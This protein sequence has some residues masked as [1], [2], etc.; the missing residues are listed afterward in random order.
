MMKKTIR[1]HVAMKTL[2]NFNICGLLVFGASVCKGNEAPQAA[3]G[4]AN[5]A[6]DKKDP[7]W[8]SIFPDGLMDLNGDDVPL[9]RLKGKMV[10]LYFSASWCAPCHLFTPHLAEFQ[11]QNEEHFEVVLVGRDSVEASQLGYMKKHNMAFP[12]TQWSDGKNTQ[13]DN[14]AEKHKVNSIP[15]LVILSSEGQLIMDDARDQIQSTPKN[16]TDLFSNKQKLDELVA[17]NAKILAKQDEA[18]QIEIQNKIRRYRKALEETFPPH[19]H[20]QKA[21]RIAHYTFDSTAE[22]SLKKSPD[23]TLENTTYQDGALSLNGKFHAS[24]KGYVANTLL[25]NL[26]YSQFS[27]GQEFLIRNLNKNQPTAIIVGGKSY[28]WFGIKSDHEGMM[29]LFFNN[30]RFSSKIPGAKISPNEW[31]RILTSVDLHQGII[32]IWLNGKLLPEID[33]PED[34]MLEVIVSTAVDRDKSFLFKNYSNRESLDGLIDN[35]VVYDGPLSDT[36]IA[37][38][39]ANFGSRWTK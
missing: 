4:H 32:R 11:N 1:H 37:E 34:F 17:A 7:V 3:A 31:N 6:S 38:E 12:S 30:G 33:L 25:A 21:T 18:A 24:E 19:S 13:S 16:I 36:E 2:L 35:V 39:A 9:E 14:L 22:D 15:R 5:Q 28:R 27:V 10:G 23:F 26:S 8:A 29:E 20:D